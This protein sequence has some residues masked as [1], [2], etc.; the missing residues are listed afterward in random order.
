MSTARAMTGDEGHQAPQLRCG[1]DEIVVRAP[2]R[3]RQVKGPPLRC[4]SHHVG[5]PYGAA[6]DPGSARQALA[7]TIKPLDHRLRFIERV[8]T[9][10]VR[11]GMREATGG[12]VW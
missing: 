7:S 3:S 6:L 9:A 11:E 4:G 10:R 8:M 5:R 1:A 2:L 12:R